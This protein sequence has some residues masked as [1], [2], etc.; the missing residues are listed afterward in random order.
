MTAGQPLNTRPP[1]LMLRLLP[2]LAA[3]TQW[4]AATGQRALRE[5]PGYALHAALRATLGELAPKPFALLERPGSQQLIG[6]T[7]A[8]EPALREALAA[9]DLTDPLAAQALGLHHPTQVVIKPMPATWTTGQRLSFETRVAPVVRSRTAQGGRYP[10]IDAAFHPALAGDD[11]GN[12]EVAHGRWLARELTRDGAAQLLSHHAVAFSLSAIAPR[13][14]AA[15]P[16]QARRQTH[17]GL[18]PD[19]T[20]RGQLQVQDPQAFAALLARG[21]GRHR[22]FGY[23]CLLLAPP[24]AWT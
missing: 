7:T 2:D 11:L 18:L 15:D 17:G 8:S 21:L 20:V 24:G 16:K 19:L 12:R 1:L 13:T 10:E 9:A 5:D 22:S 4:A 6:Y 3:L 14:F 23:G